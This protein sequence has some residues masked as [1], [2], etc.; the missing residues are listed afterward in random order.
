MLILLLGNH[1]MIAFL[2]IMWH[3]VPWGLLFKVKDFDWCLFC[4]S[5]KNDLFLSLLVYTAYLYSHFPPLLICL[6]LEWR[7]IFRFT[8][9]TLS[10]CSSI[11][12]RIMVITLA[13]KVYKVER[14]WGHLAVFYWHISSFVQNYSAAPE[15]NVLCAS[16][17][18]IKNS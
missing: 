3:L 17:S 9:V 18:D 13:L 16:W 12:L 4:F 15:H 11:H 10:I 2:W 6:H 7:W 14:K 8:H 5:L 1:K